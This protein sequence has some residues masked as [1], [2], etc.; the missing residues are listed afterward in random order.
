MNL[1][2]NW[3]IPVTDEQVSEFAIWANHQY[4]GRTQFE[5]AL[6]NKNRR[7][8]EYFF[9]T[10]LF[11]E[12]LSKAWWDS[13]ANPGDKKLQLYRRRL[14]I[15][16]T[17]TSAE[18][19]RRAFPRSEDT[20]PMSDEELRE[21]HTRTIQKEHYWQFQGIVPLYRM[22]TYPTAEDKA[23]FIPRACAIC[24]SLHPMEDTCF[25]ICGHEFGT[26]CLANWEYKTC[27]SCSE[28]CMTSVAITADK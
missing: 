17:R 13:E 19:V 6:L 22:T 15:K 12:E 4:G 21:A 24:L 18:L 5:R 14:E 1:N 3:E 28:F 2:D 7:M 10:T 20:K 16:M 23:T 8:I 11:S 25:T 27:P 9:A 26:N